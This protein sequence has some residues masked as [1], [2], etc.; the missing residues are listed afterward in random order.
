M[1][2]ED[3]QLDNPFSYVDIEFKGAQGYDGSKYYGTPLGNG[4]FRMYR[5]S[6]LPNAGGV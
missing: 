2:L 4:I 5:R 6:G 3:L 1:E